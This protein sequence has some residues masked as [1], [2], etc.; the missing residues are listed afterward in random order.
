MTN[1]TLDFWNFLSETL[2]MYQTLEGI[3]VLIVISSIQSTTSNLYIKLSFYIELSK[4]RIPLCLSLIQ[5]KNWLNL[6]LTQIQWTKTKDSSNLIWI[7]NCS[8]WF[9][10]RLWVKTIV[11]ICESDLWLEFTTYWQTDKFYW[12]MNEMISFWKL[13]SINQIKP[14]V[15]FKPNWI[16][17]QLVSQ[18]KPTSSNSN[19]ALF[20]KK[21]I[22][23][24]QT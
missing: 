15:K 1:D 8:T 17:L 22:L 16:I 20:K 23:Y 9:D 7:Q 6:N 13:F 4:P 2:S 21:I 18:T 12:I 24:T 11:W 19:L 3:S 14:L 10:L 5:I